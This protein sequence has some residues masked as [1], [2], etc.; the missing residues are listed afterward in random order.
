MRPQNPLVIDPV[1]S[2]A[3]YLGGLN[4]DFGLGV[5]VDGSGNAYITGET[6]STDFPTSAGALQTSCGGIFCFRAFVTKL[7]AAGSAL[8]Y[9]T[10][11]GGT[12]GESGF[13]IAVDASGDVYVLGGT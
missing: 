10:Y 9:S 6:Q 1:L 11:L 5:A 8:V 2:Y 7:N 13:G 3:T 12:G 4:E